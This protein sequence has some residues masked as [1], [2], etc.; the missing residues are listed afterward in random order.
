MF[1]CLTNPTPNCQQI[2]P[3]TNVPEPGNLAILGLGLLALGWT[4]RRKTIINS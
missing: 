3:P 1:G 2:D 4:R